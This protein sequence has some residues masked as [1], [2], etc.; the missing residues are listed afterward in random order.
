[1]LDNLDNQH[2][3]ERIA[4]VAPLLP[5]LRAE[6]VSPT[7]QLSPAPEPA[8]FGERKIERILDRVYDRLVNETAEPDDS[9]LRALLADALLPSEAHS[10]FPERK[11]ERIL[12]R[13]QARLA[14]DEAAISI[15]PARKPLHKPAPLLGLRSVALSLLRHL[16]VE[17]K[18]LSNKRLADE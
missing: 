8:P 12:D 2:L 1:M 3:H 5:G 4:E 13:V 14:A 15:S 18:L 10:A 17:V 16:S 6:L 7:E 9:R 11:I